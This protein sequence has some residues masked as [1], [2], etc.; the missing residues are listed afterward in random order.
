M[1]KTVPPASTPRARQN[2]LA[3]AD[4]DFPIF[5]LNS[6]ILRK[7]TLSCTCGDGA[8]TSPGKHPYAPLAPRGFKNASTE[9]ETIEAWFERA[10]WLNY[11]IRTD[12]L[13]V[14][15][16]DP[17]HDGDTCWDELEHQHG[18]VPPTWRVLTGGG[19]EHIYFSAPAGIEINSSAGTLAPGVDHRARGGYVVGPGCL[20]L[21]GGRYEWNVDGHPSEVPLAPCPKWI[22]DR[23]AEPRQAKAKPADHWHSTLAEPIKEG[24]RD[25]TI[26]SIAGKLVHHGV[27]LVL[28]QDLLACVNTACCQPPLRDGDIE[29]IVC[30]IARKHYG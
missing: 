27:D 21:S 29:R 11:G 3:F 2:A 12:R 23:L 22:S 6:I 7:G 5:P 4:R 24:C 14:I 20:H 1:N 19:G 15:D 28:V 10:P 26:T 17:R 8:C 13:V 30:S 18:D 25:T 16:I 9:V